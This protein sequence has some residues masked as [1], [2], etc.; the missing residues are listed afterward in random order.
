MEEAY[1]LIIEA[2][3]NR[4]KDIRASAVKAL[5]KIGDERGISS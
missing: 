3:N 4:D 1:A 2:L 5:G